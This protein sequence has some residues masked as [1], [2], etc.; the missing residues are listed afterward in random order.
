MARILIVTPAPQRSRAGNRVTATRWARLLRSLGHKVQTAERFASQHADLM[1][2]L[3]ARKSARSVAAFSVAYPDR[4]IIVALTGTDLYGELA[5]SATAQ[6]SLETATRLVLLQP[7]GL[8]LLPNRHQAKGRVILQSA[9]PPSRTPLPLNSTFEAC[10]CGHLRSVKDPFRTAMAVR[11]LPNESRIRITH[12]GAALTP[13]M[14]QRAISEMHRNSRYTWRG[15]VPQWRA[16]QLIA[17]SQLLVVTSKI[18]GGANVVS[19]AL[20][21][22]TP[23]VSSRISGSIGLLGADYP[24]YFDVGDTR[25]LASLLLRCEQDRDFYNT[26][27]DSCRVT[28]T[29]L[30]PDAEQAAWLSLLTELD[31]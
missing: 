27:R 31:L 19:E 5:R 9:P 7:D 24:G 1:I 6:R 28:S 25:Q 16:R 18:E 10:V 13:A 30:S 26:L 21:A 8:S 11:H 15:E 22:D 2:A 17:R 14:E 4:P 12:L 20:V 3:H 29:D 23:V